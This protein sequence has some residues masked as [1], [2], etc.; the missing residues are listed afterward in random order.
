MQSI[1]GHG[2]DGKQSNKNYVF[3]KKKI[4]FKNVVFI[5]TNYFLKTKFLSRK[6]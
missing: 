4:V 6:K 3:K 2:K 5:L 1:E